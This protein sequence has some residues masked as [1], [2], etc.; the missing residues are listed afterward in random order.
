MNG[1]RRT[2][3]IN[4]KDYDYLP[5]DL[6]NIVSRVLKGNKEVFGW[7]PKMEPLVMALAKRKPNWMF[8]NGGGSDWVVYERNEHVGSLG[9]VRHLSGTPYEIYSRTI[10]RGGRGTG[11]QRTADL[12]KAIKIV[13]SNFKALTHIEKAKLRSMDID[14]GI[15]QLRTQK[16][17]K[18][19]DVREEVYKFLDGYVLANWDVI[20][21]E[22]LRLG[23]KLDKVAA[24]VS[25]SGE[26]EE[27]GKIM[28]RQTSGKGYSVVILEGVYYVANGST[29][30]FREY[31][32]DAVPDFIKRGVGMLKLIDDGTAVS[33]IGYRHKE[34][35][36]YV[37][38]E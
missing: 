17:A 30:D 32:Q 3:T 20:S 11:G 31:Q 15:N 8:V 24:F 28:V 36:F 7:H 12:K 10:R 19:R 25:V 16:R 35:S 26:S 13:L 2:M 38:G 27:M 34:D 29:A 6:P 21:Q 5:M 22:V 33:N 1:R 18:Y 4:R 14:V 9:I 23:A 37:M